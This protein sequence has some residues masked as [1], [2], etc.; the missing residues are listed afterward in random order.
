MKYAAELTWY[1]FWIFSI[2]GSYCA[3]LFAIRYFEKKWNVDEDDNIEHK[4][5]I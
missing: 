5:H 1:I 3:S 4:K 2:I